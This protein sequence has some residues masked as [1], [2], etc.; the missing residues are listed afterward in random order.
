MNLKA[1]GHN[2][3]PNQQSSYGIDISQSLL[4]ALHARSRAFPIRDDAPCKQDSLARRASYKRRRRAT[5]ERIDK[6][7]GNKPGERIGEQGSWQRF[8]DL[9]GSGQSMCARCVG[10]TGDGCGA[11]GGNIAPRCLRRRRTKKRLAASDA[12]LHIVLASARSRASGSR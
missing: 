11:V 3:T 2:H 1:R 6:D 7:G 5:T 4:D 10:R 8:D 12:T 9:D